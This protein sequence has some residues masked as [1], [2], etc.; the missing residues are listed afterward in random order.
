MSMNGFTFDDEGNIV[1]P[2]L[3]GGGGSFEPIPDGVYNVKVDACTPEVSQNGNPYLKFVYVVIDGDHSGRKVWD[4][5]TIIAK[6]DWKQTQVFEALTR[7][8]Y[9]SSGLKI[10]PKD[11]VGLECRAVIYQNEF[12]GKVR[13][14]IEKILP[15]LS[16]SQSDGGFAFNEI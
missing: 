15:G 4:N 2:D 13:N 1:L 11:L 6:T 12:E 8:P 5:L 7:Q 14:K 9:R 10:N 16:G 3:S